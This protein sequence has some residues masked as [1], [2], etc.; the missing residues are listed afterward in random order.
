MRYFVHLA[1]PIYEPLLFYSTKILQQQNA[2]MYTIRHYTL[3]LRLAK[4]CVC[5]MPILPVIWITERDM[6]AQQLL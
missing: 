4:S 6:S 5:A 2:R 1:L 3:L